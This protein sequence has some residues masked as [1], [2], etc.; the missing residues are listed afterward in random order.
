MKKLITL[1]LIICLAAALT[2]CSSGAAQDA[3]DQGDLA[4]A[5]GDYETAMNSYKLAIDKGADDEETVA[6]YNLLKDFVAIDDAINAGS[7]QLAKEMADGLSGYEGTPAESGFKKLIQKANACYDAMNKIDQAQGYI[8]DSAYAEATV[9]LDSIETPYIT[10]DLIKKADSLRE[11]VNNKKSTA[12]T[13]TT[14]III[15]DGYYVP[16]NYSGVVPSYSGSVLFPSDSQY[17]TN[18]YLDM[19]SPN[20]VALIRNEIYARHGYIFQ[21]TAYK[22]YFGSKSWYYGQ[23]TDQEYVY[24][25]MNSIEKTNIETISNYE[26][27]HGWK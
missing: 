6:M 15:P 14:T 20:E 10:D 4:I 16:S 17:I 13:S 1:L 26:K 18:D 8:N 9:V 5:G 23:Y 12:Q 7:Y 25:L 22:N 3:I 24:S 11:T 27:S 19:C 21:K 2:A